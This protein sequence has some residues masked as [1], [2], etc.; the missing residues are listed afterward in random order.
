MKKHW[1]LVSFT[2]AWSLWAAICFAFAHSDVNSND[3]LFWSIASGLA[4]LLSWAIVA[5]VAGPW[6]KTAAV[7]ALAFA[8]LPRESKA[9]DNGGGDQAGGNAIV[10]LV[11][12]IVVL[13]GGVVIYVSLKKMC[14]HLPPA[15]PPDAEP[16][17]PPPW[18][19]NTN[20]INPSLPPYY[21]TNGVIH[22]NIIIR[23]RLAMAD[24][25][26]VAYYDA[27]GKGWQ[28]PDGSAVVVLAKTVLETSDDLAHWQTLYQLSVYASATGTEVVYRDSANN[29]LMSCAA[30][31]SGGTWGSVSQ[32]PELG[33]DP[34]RFYRLRQP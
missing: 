33:S 18:H 6:K 15:N 24:S 13:V 32:I 3:A 12:G 26:G 11:C 2:A 20:L 27:S 14:S 34:K 4:L 8:F 31:A 21:L 9:R 30:P 5:L 7:L 23:P 25:Q 29:L 16:P 22:T 19:G 17:P 10:G 1:K 28:N